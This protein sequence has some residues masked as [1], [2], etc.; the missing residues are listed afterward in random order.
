MTTC[1]ISGEVSGPTDGG[2][3]PVDPSEM[4]CEWRWRGGCARAQLVDEE[5]ELSCVSQEQRPSYLDCVALWYASS[6]RRVVSEQWDEGGVG[7]EILW[8]QGMI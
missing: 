8:L 7:G 4:N 1:V 6:L 5:S 3:G 2:D